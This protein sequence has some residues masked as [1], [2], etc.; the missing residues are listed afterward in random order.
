MC[1]QACGQVQAGG[2]SSRRG[3]ELI[4]KMKQ[5]QEIVVIS[6]SF[7]FPFFYSHREKKPKICSNENERTTQ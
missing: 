5:E 1:R 3:I 4:T 7:L 6:L 2:G